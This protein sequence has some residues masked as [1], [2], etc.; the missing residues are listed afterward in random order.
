[1]LDWLLNPVNIKYS[2][3]LPLWSI[4][5]WSTDPWSIAIA[6]ITIANWPT[7]PIALVSLFN[8]P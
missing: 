7:D 5:P 3:Y 4:G 8:I 2:K 6:P 1:M